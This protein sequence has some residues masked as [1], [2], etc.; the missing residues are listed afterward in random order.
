MRL[1][2]CSLADDIRSIIIAS[3]CL[4][5]WHRCMADKTNTQKIQGVWLR[6]GS[7][8]ETTKNTRTER[9]E[10][11]ERVNLCRYYPTPSDVSEWV[12]P[13]LWILLL[14]P[15]PIHA[16]TQSVIVLIKTSVLP[17]SIWPVRPNVPVFKDK[18]VPAS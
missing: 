11:A 16:S 4:A 1:I 8:V 12:K 18:A 15:P 6:Q 10:C 14:T 2:G 5:F 17:P 9:V 7:K 13:E 3:G